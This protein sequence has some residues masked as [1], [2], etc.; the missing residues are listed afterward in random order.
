MSFS[1]PFFGRKINKFTVTT[2]GALLLGNSDA[3]IPTPSHIAPFLSN[4]PPGNDRVRFTDHEGSFTAEWTEHYLHDDRHKQE[5]QVNVYQ[6][7]S[8]TFLYKNLLPQLFD[9]AAETG[10]P[11]Q[12][13]LQDGFAVKQ[14]KDDVRD[15]GESVFITCH[16][17]YSI[18]GTVRY[19]Q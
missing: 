12:I 7:G 10:Y 16:V 19:F 11:I 13:G 8:I 14:D 4:F 17:P 6:D 15:G 2:A 1:F 3:E 5:Y 18:Y 9:L